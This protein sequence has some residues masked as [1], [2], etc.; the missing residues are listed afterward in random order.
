MSASVTT[1][2]RRRGRWRVLPMP[3]LHLVFFGIVLAAYA[4]ALA[5]DP[6]LLRFLP[7]VPQLV[8]AFGEIAV[9]PEFW[10]AVGATGNAVA[11]GLSISMVAG[12][13]FAL[14]LSIH[15]SIYASF[16][17]L[18][19][20]LRTI[21]PLALIPVGLLLM[22]PTLRMEV[23]LIVASAVWPV[24]LQVYYGIVH[25]DH[26]FIETARSFRLGMPRTVWFVVAPGVAP[27]FATAL[28][29]AT[30]MTLL[31]AVGTELLAGTD[32]LGFLVGWYQ[33]A[34]QIPR[35]YAV[36]IVVGLLGVAINALIK[37]GERRLLSWIEVAR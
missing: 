31:L 15:P 7:T 12:S 27:S 22:G 23:T 13:L 24:V 6:G 18:V 30:A 21:P 10:S 29:L 37:L 32:G 19:D 1:V 34:H 25:L 5:L 26:R 17:F 4:A 9:D 3:A 14:L 2:R 8:G 36:I 33:Q 35:M 11:L 28:R 20:F 16:R